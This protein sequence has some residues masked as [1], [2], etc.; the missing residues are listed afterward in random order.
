MQFIESNL[1]ITQVDVADV[2]YVAEPAKAISKAFPDNLA[3][4]F[5]VFVAQD[6]QVYGVV[7]QRG[8][9]QAYA[10]GSGAL[11]NIIRTQGRL[12]E[13]KVRERDLAQINEDLRTHAQMNGKEG[14][15]WSRVAPIEAG[16][17][18]DIGD[19]THHRIR[20]TPG[21]VSVV[22]EGS[23]SRFHRQSTSG[24]LA[25]PADEGDLSLLKKYLNMTDERR[26]LFF[27]WLSYTLA[28]PKVSTTKYVMLAL[29][30]GQ[31]SGK[32]SLCQNVIQALID[33]ST[34][35]VQKLS[36]NAQ[37]FGLVIQRNH[38][39]CFDNLRRLTTAMSDD[40]CIACTGG[41]ATKRK[42]YSDSDQHAIRL[43][44]A[45]VLNGIHAFIEE[46]DLAQR[47]LTITLNGIK[48]Q[49]RKTDTAMQCELQA[50]MP[51]IF[52]G[53]LDLIAN[54]FERLPDV[55][56]TNPERMMEFSQWLGA[57]EL[58]DGAPNGAY[59]ELF[60]EVI[61]EGQYD[62]MQE[63]VL[64][65]ALITFAHKQG[66]KGW[67]GTPTQLHGELNASVPIETQRDKAWPKSAISLSKKLQPI[68]GLLLNQGVDVDISRGRERRISVK[69]S[70]SSADE[71][72]F[73]VDANDSD[74]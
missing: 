21:N 57:M 62:A 59:Q 71:T 51:K 41:T 6:G 64:C 8:N 70:R 42:L 32:T 28:H 37:D 4:D 20:V 49:D 15:V 7:S 14:T 30:G 3:D 54:V 36:T 22:M 17:E 53:L 44:G 16:I 24:S 67:S 60:S 34:L 65:V 48:P 47:A 10:V 31:G 74:F 68:T 69:C 38:V 11:N 2:S 61:S 23:K 18:I 46:P 26:I 39:A 50:D 56:L 66:A 35:G 45:V 19:D 29:L 12:A 58:V 1:Q 40:L 55:N 33:P 73:D 5:D 72:L 27:A 9:T 63:S 13:K 52:R 25:R 43:H